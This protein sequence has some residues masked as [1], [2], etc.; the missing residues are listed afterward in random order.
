MSTSA[1]G[2]FGSNGPSAEDAAKQFVATWSGGDTANAAKQTDSADSAKKLM[3][4]VRGG[5]KPTAV[6]G[7]VQKVDTP[8]DGSTGKAQFT[9]NWDLGRNRHWTYAGE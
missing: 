3:D 7:E 5:L 4:R 6:T 9:M 8:G 1:C 2:L